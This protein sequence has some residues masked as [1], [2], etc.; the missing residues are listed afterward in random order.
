MLQ[1]LPIVIR[2]IRSFVPAPT[3]IS[4]TLCPAPATTYA[5]TT[6]PFFW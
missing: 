5:S 4:P 6:L 1:M 2:I 3:A